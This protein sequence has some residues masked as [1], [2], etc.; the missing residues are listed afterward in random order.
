MRTILRHRPREE[1]IDELQRLA[2]ELDRPPTTR[3]MNEQGKFSP[4]PFKNLFGSWIEALRAAGLEPT[5][6]QLRRSG[7]ALNRTD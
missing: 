1:L 5:G 4:S 2:Q 7:S 6:P 3:Q